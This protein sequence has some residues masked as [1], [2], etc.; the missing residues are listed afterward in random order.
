MKNGVSG[1]SRNIQRKNGDL[2]PCPQFQTLS[3]EFHFAGYKKMPTF[4]PTIYT[5]QP[6]RTKPTIVKVRDFLEMKELLFG[7]HIWCGRAQNLKK[8]KKRKEMVTFSLHFKPFRSENQLN[9]E[10][11]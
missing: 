5:E 3:Y 9:T 11:P 8:K 6:M 4:K 2:L 1:Y 10:H 7:I